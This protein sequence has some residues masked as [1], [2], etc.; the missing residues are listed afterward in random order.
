MWVSVCLHVC[1]SVLPRENN[2]PPTVFSKPK[3]TNQSIDPYRSL[4][5]AS[6]YSCSSPL[7]RK[8]GRLATTVGF[9]ST[10]MCVCV[11]VSLMVKGGGRGAILL[12]HLIF[13]QFVYLLIGHYLT[14][15]IPWDYLLALFPLCTPAWSWLWSDLV[16]RTNDILIEPKTGSERN[17][18]RGNFC[19]VFCQG[20][21]YCRQKL[22][23][24][25][26]KTS[27]QCNH[28]R[29]HT[30]INSSKIRS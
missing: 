18:T 22:R 29:S 1:V 21:F 23:A 26:I 20:E 16:A 13:H 14:N 30:F 6:S 24:K 2:A 25:R 10:K 4:S 5:T 12:F 15:Y 7:Y 3:Q 27:E 17:A 19:R 11:C 28:M 8:M 9:V